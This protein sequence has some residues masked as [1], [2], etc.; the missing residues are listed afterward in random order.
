MSISLNRKWEKLKTM[1]PV[2]DDKK[3]YYETLD[4][5]YT[6]LGNK[7]LEDK[8]ILDFLEYYDLDSKLHIDYWNIFDDLYLIK[9]GNLNKSK[10]FC[11]VS[12]KKYLY[13]KEESNRKWEK[14]KTMIPVIG[15]KETY[16]EALD[17]YYEEFGNMMLESDMILNFLEYY[18]LDSKLHI[19]YWNVFDDLYLVKEENLK[20]STSLK[21][22]TTKKQT[23]SNTSSTQSQRKR[24]QTKNDTFQA[25]AKTASQTPPVQKQS[26]QNQNAS[27]TLAEHKESFY[28]Y[29]THMSDTQLI[30]TID[31]QYKSIK[32]TWN[33]APCMGKYGSIEFAAVL[34]LWRYAT[35][36]FDRNKEAFASLQIML[37][38]M[39]CC[40]F[41]GMP[42]GE[43]SDKVDPILNTHAD[44]LSYDEFG[45]VYNYLKD[46]LMNKIHSLEF[47]NGNQTKEV[48][49]QIY[50]MFTQLYNSMQGF[51]DTWNF[52]SEKGLKIKNDIHFR[53][54]DKYYDDLTYLESQLSK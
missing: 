6:E 32:G 21:K 23:I 13:T 46:N 52:Y 3:T 30:N 8:M 44:I 39:I 18:N 41:F 17:L 35:A 7:M 51:V 37:G 40:A 25:Q 24:T 31:D 47:N 29:V 48:Y 34:L 27:N 10:T 15:D 36:N 33:T 50:K 20:K 19:D 42:A 49:G 53:I 45:D 11:N 43:W 28:S 12:P 2:I 14:L 5:F 38:D 16:Y 22:Q 54:A 26:R 1:I 4:L 9:E